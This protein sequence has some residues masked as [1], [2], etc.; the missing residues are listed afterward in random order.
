[1]R[2]NDLPSTSVQTRPARL[3]QIDVMR[4]LICASVVA[5]HVVG[6]ANPIASVAPNAVTNLLHYTRQAFFFISAL[7][8][9]HAYREGRPGQLRRRVS[10]LG[11]PYVVWS[12]IYAVI[13][14]T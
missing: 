12:T 5:T 1:M 8:L 13:G 10:V 3:L 2:L 6:N 4:L 9:V 7:V 14:L 11:V